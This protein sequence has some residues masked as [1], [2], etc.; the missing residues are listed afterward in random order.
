MENRSCPK[1]CGHPQLLVMVFHRTAMHVLREPSLW[2][3][4]GD[5]S[6]FPTGPE[7]HMQLCSP[8]EATLA[9]SP[10]QTRNDRDKSFEGPPVGMVSG[11]RQKLA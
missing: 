3:I 6:T 11:L 1:C 2:S 10:V 9:S 4:G 5:Y 7:Q 8:G